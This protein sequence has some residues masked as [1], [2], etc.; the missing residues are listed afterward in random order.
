VNR[1]LTALKSVPMVTGQVSE[2]LGVAISKEFIVRKLK[3]KPL[4]ET[5][6]SAYWDDINLI[7]ARMGAYFTKA[8]KL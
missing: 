2:E 7:K 6:T 5:K 8:S 3:V 4:L 1:K